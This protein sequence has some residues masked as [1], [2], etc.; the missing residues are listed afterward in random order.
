ML[1]DGKE[2]R[3]TIVM[4]LFA[5]STSNSSILHPHQP[6]GEFLAYGVL[7]AVGQDVGVGE[8]GNLLERLVLAAHLKRT[9]SFSAISD[10]LLK[11]F[12]RVTFFWGDEE[13]RGKSEVRSYEI[14]R[15]FTLDDR[16]KEK[17]LKTFFFSVS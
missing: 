2:G 15:C 3:H 8:V 10:F 1:M 4:P 6:Q 12:T 11:S 5:V 9:K 7:Y 13:G 16:D 17:T 14:L